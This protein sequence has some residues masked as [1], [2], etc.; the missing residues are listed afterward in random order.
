MGILFLRVRRAV[1]YRT[2]GARLSWTTAIFRVRIVNAII[3]ALLSSRA[4]ASA[5][6]IHSSGF[7][8]GNAHRQV[9]T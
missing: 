5:A 6:L 4:T 9:Q 3:F 8:V 1:S 7:S 2:D